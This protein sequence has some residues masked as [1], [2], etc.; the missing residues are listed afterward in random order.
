MIRPLT[1]VCM[2]LA[3]ASGLYLY[4]SKHR[5]QMLDREIGRTMKLTEAA[6]DRTG[7]LRGEWALLNEP[8]RL[9]ALSHTHL[10]LKTLI[11]S[12]FVTVA[13][14]SDRL[15]SPAAPGAFV[16]A[17]ED[18]ELAT[19]TAAHIPVPTPIPAARPV[20]K[21]PSPILA[22]AAP[23]SVPARTSASPRPAAQAIDRREDAAQSRP[24]VQAVSVSSPSPASLPSRTASAG[25]GAS[26]GESVAR[27]ARL[28]GD[29]QPGYA[30]SAYAHPTYVQPTFAQP[31]YTQAS[32]QAPTPAAASVLGGP[33]PLLPPPVPF[34]AR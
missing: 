34:G 8:E 18:P 23:Q 31:A 3:C 16:P 7:V 32:I 19:P 30:Q 20:I 4:Q 9:A 5:A 22:V 33:R 13:D 27:A 28:R 15:P 2:L 24:S 14:L 6:R 10:G 26:I 25:P 1:C 11:P 21:T 17:P 29:T 12:Q